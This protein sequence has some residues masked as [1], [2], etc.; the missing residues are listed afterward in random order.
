M[1]KQ[2]EKEFVKRNSG[3]EHLNELTACTL[4]KG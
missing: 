3:F 2:Y 1:K 4:H